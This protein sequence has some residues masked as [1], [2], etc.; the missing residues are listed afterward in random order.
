MSDPD[1]LSADQLRDI[2]DRRIRRR[3]DISDAQ[4]LR[5][6]DDQPVVVVVGAQP[7]AG[8]SRAIDRVRRDHPTAVEVIGDDLRRFHPRYEQVMGEDPLQMPHVTAQASGAW[9]EMSIDYLRSQRR[10]VIVET[11]MRQPAVVEQ[12][13]RSFR[14]AGYATEVRA[15]AVP[16][17]LSRLGTVSRYAEQVRANGS[18]RWTP[19]S[20]HD[21]AAEA[22]LETL[23]QII[24]R[25]LADRVVVSN[26]AGH[27]LLD[28]DIDP[29]MVAALDGVEARRVVEA[30][31]LVSSIPPGQAQEWLSTF[32]REVSFCAERGERDPDM[33]TTLHTLAEDAESVARSAFPNS[34]DDRSAAIAAVREIRKQLPTRPTAP[35]EAAPPAAHGAAFPQRPGMTPGPRAP[36]ARRREQQQ[37]PEQGM[38]R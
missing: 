15:L 1:R 26:R 11:T 19:S 2:F 29:T 23:E 20:G 30:G 21:S 32:A 28:R 27:A 9:V 10:S 5:A 13:L 38:E 6:V 34:L 24:S 33:V 18:G 17:E 4:P 16:T 37:P 7:G 25:G 31:R 14:E 22:M 3:F 36:G 8:K 35:V 12:T